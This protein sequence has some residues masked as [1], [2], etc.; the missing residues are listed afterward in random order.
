MDA[1]RLEPFTPAAALAVGR[2][3][4]GETDPARLT[5]SDEQRAEALEHAAELMVKAHA[6]RATLEVHWTRAEPT[7]LTIAGH[8]EHLPTARGEVAVFAPDDVAEH[9]LGGVPILHDETVRLNTLRAELADMRA[10]DAGP[11]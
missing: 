9:T 8:F 10:K 3:G 6:E 1:L 2:M 5:T 11:A 4:L 7:V